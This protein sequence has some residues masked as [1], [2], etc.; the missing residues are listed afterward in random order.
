M[1]LTLYFPTDDETVG[2]TFEDENGDP[3]YFEV[4][5]LPD[6]TK[7]SSPKDSVDL[8]S[9]QTFVSHFRFCGFSFVNCLS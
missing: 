8:P 5:F 9:S 1:E 6:G 3:K 4:D 2:L 7:K